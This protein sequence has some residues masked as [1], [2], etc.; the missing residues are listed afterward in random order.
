MLRADKQSF[1]RASYV[2]LTALA[3][4]LSGC[5]VRTYS[6]TR[7]RVDQDLTQQSGNRGYLMGSPSEETKDRPTTRTTQVVEIELHS[8]IKFDKKHRKNAGTLA[9]GTGESVTSAPGGYE[10][11]TVDQ[12]GSDIAS[13]AGPNEKYTVQKGDTLQKISM[14]YYGTT[15]RWMKLYKANQDKLSGPDKVRPGQVLDI[16]TDP[17]AK[18]SVA[19]P[20]AEPQQNFK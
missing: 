15:K 18:K 10:Y 12:P 4:I 9:A 6:L 13:K 17:G 8:P 16:P 19:E 7:D 2:M 3:F 5:V 14:K 20:M 11:V 1:T